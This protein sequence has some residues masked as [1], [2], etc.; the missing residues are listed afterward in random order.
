MEPHEFIFFMF[1]SSTQIV[2]LLPDVIDCFQSK[3]LAVVESDIMSHIKAVVTRKTIKYA[4]Y[5]H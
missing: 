5:R 2:G 3:S 1:T 4:G